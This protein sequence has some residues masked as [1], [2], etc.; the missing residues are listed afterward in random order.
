MGMAPELTGG[1]TAAKDGCAEFCVLESLVS[2][3]L[4]RPDH[5]TDL[6]GFFVLA[7][8]VLAKER[9]MRH[10]LG[11]LGVL[12]AGVLLAVSAAMNW[13]FGYSLGRDEFDGQLFGAA[14]AAA[15]CLKALTPFFFFAAIRNRVWSQAVAAAV[16]WVV[17]TGYSL[18]SALGLAAQNRFE[19]TGERTQSAQVYEGLRA[20]LKR[21]EDK[22]NWIPP[23]RPYEAVQ[24][25]I[26][27]LKTQNAWKWSEGCNKATGRSE[28]KLCSQYHALNAELAAAASARTAQDQIATIKEKLA[29]VNGAQAL[30]E[31]DPQ[32]RVLTELASMVMPNVTV[33]NMQ[34]AMTVFLALLLEIGSGF[35][36]YVAFSTWRLDDRRVP[37]QA[38][39][40]IDAVALDATSTAAAAV[41]QAVRTPLAVDVEKP[42]STANDNASL[43]IELDRPA[44]AAPM[45]SEERSETQVA[46]EQRQ[47]TPQRRLAPETNT[48]RFYK[49]NIDVQ[50]G[51]SVTAQDLYDDYC[52]WCDVNNR[53]P[54][55]MPSF[56]R[57]FADLGVRKEKV[58]GRVRYIGIAL[59][60][61]NTT[62][63]TKPPLYRTVAA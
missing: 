20:D 39:R 31:A 46:A 58:A 13:S 49:E 52:T 16:V 3:S 17:V 28:Q 32:A 22:A 37:A 6:T 34:V 14:S 8:P 9:A 53:E 60:S 35:G 38:P 27:R 23:H 33:D 1:T 7:F 26:E 25:E 10:V 57:E 48:E 56:A 62:E 30:S 19:Q 42:R 21:A 12:A 50:D 2:A 59:K 4:G 5:K 54:S 55:S 15:D 47:S 29:A 43:Q 51:S 11:V 61:S 40:Q 36:M 41:A 63:A 44:L 24:S 18:T 45:Q